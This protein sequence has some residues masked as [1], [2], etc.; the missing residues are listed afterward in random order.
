[1]LTNALLNDGLSSPVQA[2]GGLLRCARNDRLLRR[3]R[4]LNDGAIKPSAG[5]QGVATSLTS[6]V[7]RNDGA[8][9]IIKYPS[10]N[11]IKHIIFFA[12]RVLLSSEPVAANHLIGS[13]NQQR[14]INDLNQRTVIAR[15]HSRRSNLLM[16]CTWFDNPTKLIFENCS[17]KLNFKISKNILGLMRQ[18]YL[19]T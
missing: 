1:M 18:I 5:H 19:S 14:R 10:F 2:I 12:R 16:A 13:Q 3:L 15:R 4:L 8:R 17:I 7:P 11:T 6:F 9:R